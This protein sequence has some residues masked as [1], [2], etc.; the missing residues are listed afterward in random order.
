[1]LGRLS[2]NR[3]LLNH[4]LARR[5]LRTSCRL[6]LNHCLPLSGL[7]SRGLLLHHRLTS[8]NSCFCLLLPVRHL[9]LPSA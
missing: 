2:A 6:L 8:F 3:S 9:P 4:W 7:R 5:Y 1:M